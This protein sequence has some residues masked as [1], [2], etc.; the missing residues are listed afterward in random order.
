MMISTLSFLQV[1]WTRLTAAIQRCRRTYVTP[2]VLQGGRDMVLLRS[3]GWVDSLADIP[4]EAISCRY[5]AEKQNIVFTDSS[6]NRFVR[7]PWLSVVDDS[8]DMTEFFTD[9]RI[10]A[11]H[12]LL[13]EEVMSLYM[14]QRLR[15]PVAPIQITTRD[16]DEIELGADFQEVLLE[17]N[18]EA[19]ESEKE[20]EEAE[21]SE[22]ESEG[23]SPD[24][25]GNELHVAGSNLFPTFPVLDF[26]K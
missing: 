2:L 16:G 15:Y 26:I 20:N 24:I 6:N 1:Q 13:H 14:H 4:E 21:E 11:N 3:G 19:E 17:E 23:K 8:H 7:F 12:D 22:K 10:S 18:E 5:D 25:S 9:L